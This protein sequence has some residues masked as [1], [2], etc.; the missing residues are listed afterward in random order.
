MENILATEFSDLQLHLKQTKKRTNTEVLPRCPG[1]I[2]DKLLIEVRLSE[3]LTSLTVVHGVSTTN[4]DLPPRPTMPASHRTLTSLSTII[5][6]VSVASSD[7][8]KKKKKR[9][10]DPSQL[11]Q[12]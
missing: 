11:K 5:L 12:L 1:S 9:E 10:R 3:I 4:T 6:R 8:K 7:K 2:E